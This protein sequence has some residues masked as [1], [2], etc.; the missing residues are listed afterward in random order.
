MADPNY[1]AKVASAS[2]APL[3]TLSGQMTGWR[4]SLGMVQLL[5]SH[6][7]KIE[8]QILASEGDQAVHPQSSIPFDIRPSDWLNPRL[9]PDL[10]AEQ[11]RLV[12]QFREAHPEEREEGRLAEEV[13]S[14]AN[15]CRNLADSFKSHR[16]QMNQSLPRP[17]PSMRSSTQPQNS[18]LNSLLK[19]MATGDGLIDTTT[20]QQIRQ[21]QQQLLIQQYQQMNP[22]KANIP[23]QTSTSAT[24]SFHSTHSTNTTHSASSGPSHPN[25]QASYA[26]QA[27]A[28]A[29]KA[30][31]SFQTSASSSAMQGVSMTSSASGSAAMPKHPVASGVPKNN[32]AMQR[33]QPTYPGIPNSAAP[34]SAEY[35]TQLHGTHSTQPTRNVHFGSTIHQQQHSTMPTRPMSTPSGYVP[36]ASNNLPA[37]R[38]LQGQLPQGYGAAAP[39]TGYRP[40]NQTQ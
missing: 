28:T 14:H 5:G 34:P 35:Q 17:G 15:V 9:Y 13:S 21:Q 30:D 29:T 27:T 25:S 4:S 39:S 23:A 24:S 10:Y 36:G 1:F 40:P 11:L 6:V 8:S 37:Q 20:Q 16:E 3:S 33:G 18:N 2:S 19:A 22:S 32:A 12:Q 7:G 26:Q 38:N 31:P